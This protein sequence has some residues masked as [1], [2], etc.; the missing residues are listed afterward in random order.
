M[1]V[2]LA[3]VLGERFNEMFTKSPQCSTWPS[4]NDTPGV[5][6]VLRSNQAEPVFLFSSLLFSFS[7]S[8]PLVFFLVIIAVFF[9]FFIYCICLA[10]SQ[11]IFTQI[12]AEVQ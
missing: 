8:F 11:A 5:Q 2:S 6:K 12:E 7:F 9:C 1:Q 4:D 3:E 10:I